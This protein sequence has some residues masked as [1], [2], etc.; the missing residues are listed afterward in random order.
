LGSL[1]RLRIGLAALVVL[2]VAASPVLAHAVGL[3]CK[4]LEKSVRVEA[5]FSDDTPAM[6]AL[7]VVK[8][9]QGE[10]IVQGR[11]DEKGVW[12]FDR[13]V[14]GRYEISVDAGAGHRAK[15]ALTVPEPAAGSGTP[16][17]GTGDGPAREDFTRVPWLRLAAG[18]ALIFV[19][20]GCWLGRARIGRYRASRL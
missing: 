11:T 13:P 10:T 5:Y 12:S 6:D 19:L 8:N 2:A 15:E 4:L 18:L 17:V 14:A 7:I 9:E 16:A 3:S 20:A 1:F